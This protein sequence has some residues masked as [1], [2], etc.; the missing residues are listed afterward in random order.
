MKTWRPDSCDCEINLSNNTF[1]QR[2]KLHAAIPNT[3]IVHAHNR[4]LGNRFGKLPT[5]AQ[6]NIME[7]E[8]KD[9]R[10]RIRNL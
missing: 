1:I 7:Q 5:E 4:A 8:R 9:E 3:S 2:C 10:N 6:Q